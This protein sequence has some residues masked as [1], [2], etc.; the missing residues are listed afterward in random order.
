MREDRGKVNA[1]LEQVFNK[2]VDKRREKRLAVTKL[3]EQYNLPDFLTSS[4]INFNK[5]LI[6]ADDF[7]LFALTS[8]FL[9]KKIDVWFSKQEINAY[10]KDKYH[11]EKAN[12]PLVFS[13]IQ[14]DVDHYIGR[15]T[16][17]ELLLLSDAQLINYNENAQ[18]T[19]KHIV[20]G[21]SETWQP[22]LNKKQVANIKQSLLEEKYIPDTITLNI[23]DE[24]GIEFEYDKEKL[25]LTVYHINHFDITD[26]YHRYIAMRQAVAEDPVV[27]D[28]VIELRLTNFS[29]SKAA[30]F[31]W[32]EDQK[33]HMKKVDS[34]SMNPLKLANHIVAR[35]DGDLE[36]V[37]SGQIS[38][39]MGLVNAAQFADV[40][41]KIYLKDVKKSSEP[42]IKV[43]VQNE[44]TTFIE[45]VSQKHVEILEKRWDKKFILA[46]VYESKYGSVDTVF[47][48][49]KKIMSD[50]SIYA[51]Q[52]LKPVDIQKINKLLG[53]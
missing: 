51:G 21:K 18:R 16:I 1:A 25:E 29:I 26:G 10:S 24:N 39:N 19:L 2:L 41:E 15:I 50:K 33:T 46:V 17:G 6:E 11:T 53:K 45:K 40:I 35:M 34:E 43:S 28:K 32:Q 48:T 42:I 23:P 49:Y 52:S 27:A 20:K 13:T 8:Y 5:N 37:L 22:A 30:Q 14:I 38:R 12:F 47:S 7:T 3:Y 9:P 31:I 44:L 36:F 4:F